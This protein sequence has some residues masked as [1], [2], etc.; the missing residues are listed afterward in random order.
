MMVLHMVVHVFLEAQVIAEKRV[1]NLIRSRSYEECMV[2]TVT[3][4]V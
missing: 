2:L 3:R 1:D 4:H